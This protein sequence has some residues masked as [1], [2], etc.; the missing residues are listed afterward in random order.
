MD[1]LAVVIVEFSASGFEGSRFSAALSFP[2]GC[3][4]FVGQA[5]FNRAV[6]VVDVAYFRNVPAGV[7]AD[8]RL[9]S[10]FLRRRC[11]F[12]RCVGHYPNERYEKNG[13]RNLKPVEF[14]FLYA[15]QQFFLYRC[16]LFCG[17]SPFGRSSVHTRKVCVK[18]KY[19]SICSPSHQKSVPCRGLPGL[20]LGMRRCADVLLCLSCRDAFSNIAR[21][22]WLPFSR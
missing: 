22:T 8:E 4:G 6:S 5:V 18:S 21:K 11:A 9:D 13:E 7:V 2:F 10:F 12:F 16:F 20:C 17:L 3:P 14:I 15:P 19:P 1:G